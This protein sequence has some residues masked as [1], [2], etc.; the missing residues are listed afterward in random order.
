MNVLD[1]EKVAGLLVNAGWTPVESP[2]KADLVL[3]NTCSV[4]EKAA[5]RVYAHLGQMRGLKRQR[6]ELLLGVMGC[7][8]QQEGEEM[9]RQTKGLNLVVGTRRWHLIPHH[10]ERL[11]DGETPTVVD[12]E[13]DEAPVPVEVDT[14]LRETP[15]RAFV[16][17]MEGCDN[18][19]AYCVVPHVRGRERSRPAAVILQEIRDLTARGVIEIMLLGQN[20]NSYR[21]PSSRGLSFARLLDE[22]AAVPNLRR[23]R[24][25]T[26]HPKDFQRDILDVMLAR[27]AICRQLHLPAQ[28][29]SSAVLKAMNRRYSRDGYLARV[30]MIRA[31]T[32]DF[33]LS[34]DFIVGFPG[35]TTA[36]FQATLSLLEY[37]RYDSIFSFIYSPR[38]N[39]AAAALAD[40]VPPEEK[41]ERLM[42][43]QALQERIQLASNRREIGRQHTV[44]VD[45]HGREP[46]QLASR[47]DSNKIVHFQGDAAL[48]GQFVDVCITGASSHTLQAEMIPPSS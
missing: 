26:S 34:S 46:G 27:P 3:F 33:S 39:T 43:L 14:V 11:L 41:R 40:T 15:F 19:C 7:V 37:V 6:P 22:I 38:P 4:R 47:T 16:T 17:I 5:R 12:V 44:L 25:T 24:F 45:G 2:A 13:M 20:V 32:E 28:S 29:G 1:S 21:D 31:A 42:T 30:D 18:Y 36:D 9:I 48:M 10:L 35:E 23:L 8:A